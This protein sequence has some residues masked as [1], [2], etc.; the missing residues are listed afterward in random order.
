VAKLPVEEAHRGRANFVLRRMRRQGLQ[1]DEVQR[2]R[3]VALGIRGLK[4]L[5]NGIEHNGLPAAP[6][7]RL[8]HRTLEHE[9]DRPTAAAFEHLVQEREMFCRTGERESSELLAEALRPDRSE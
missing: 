4:R 5:A 9:I 7:E 2:R 6:R 3:S 1:R 8:A